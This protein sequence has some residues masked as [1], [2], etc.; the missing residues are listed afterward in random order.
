MR[1]VSVL[2]CFYRPDGSSSATIDWRGS[3]EGVGGLGSAAMAPKACHGRRPSQGTHMGVGA[4]EI[5]SQTS[6]CTL[7]T[8]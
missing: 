5:H 6:V 8:T 3:G 7:I 2:A 4:G 1:P